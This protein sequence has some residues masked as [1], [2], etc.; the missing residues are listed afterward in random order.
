MEIRPL[1][2]SRAAGADVQK[3]R[4]LS[5]AAFVFDI[6]AVYPANSCVF[7]TGGLQYINHGIGHPWATMIVSL[8]SAI[9][10]RGRTE[11]DRLLSRWF[12]RRGSS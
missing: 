10:V 11:D 6:S 1:P 4:K 8:R 12:L 7:S 2:R 5:D 3:A 9:A